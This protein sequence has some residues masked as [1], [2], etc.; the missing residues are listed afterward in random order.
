MNRRQGVLIVVT[1]YVNEVLDGSDVGLTCTT[2]H[3]EVKYG[4]QSPPLTSI[5]AHSIFEPRL[6]VLLK[7][8]ARCKSEDRQL[9][10][11]IQLSRNL[12]ER[13]QPSNGNRTGVYNNRAA[14]QS[15][16]FRLKN[17]YVKQMCER[18]KILQN[19]NKYEN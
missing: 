12:L 13:L 4:S 17:I 8:L 6:T 9:H 10:L 1:V 3:Q 15:L 16:T 18:K 14:S 7:L 19:K 5:M 11:A 2:Q